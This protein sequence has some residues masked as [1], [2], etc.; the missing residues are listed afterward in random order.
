MVLSGN[1]SD[2]RHYILVMA[3]GTGHAARGRFPPLLA[4][5]KCLLPEAV[6]FGLPNASAKTLVCQRWFGERR[7]VVNARGLNHV[8]GNTFRVLKDKRCKLQLFAGRGREM[9]E[10]VGPGQR[11]RGWRQTAAQAGDKGFFCMVERAKRQRMWERAAYP[12]W[13]ER[14]RNRR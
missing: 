14:R 4:Q 13:L 11:E 3:R 8:A 12:D 7:S 10:P 9:N 2:E 5:Q 1:V 6:W